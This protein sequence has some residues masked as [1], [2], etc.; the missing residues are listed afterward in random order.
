MNLK[1]SCAGTS[2]YSQETPGKGSWLHNLGWRSAIPPV[3][4]GGRWPN[5][6]TK[7]HMLTQTH[8]CTSTQKSVHIR[9]RA[10]LPYPYVDEDALNVLWLQKPFKRFHKVLQKH[11]GDIWICAALG[12]CRWSAPLICPPESQTPVSPSIF[13]P[14]VWSP[15]GSTLVCPRHI[16]AAAA[17][18]GLH[19]Y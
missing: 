8:T 11:G 15:A 19:I 17:T 18:I 12:V 13:L 10:Y 4:C 9:A 7:I 2:L 5:P 1:H 3:N 16:S 14:S 6:T